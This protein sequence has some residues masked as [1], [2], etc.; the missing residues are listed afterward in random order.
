MNLL[1]SVVFE[2]RHDQG[3]ANHPVTAGKREHRA[4]QD[5]KVE[6]AYG[7]NECAKWVVHTGPRLL[8]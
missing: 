1:R 3:D 2:E 5:E 4:P 8:A 6:Q 7:V